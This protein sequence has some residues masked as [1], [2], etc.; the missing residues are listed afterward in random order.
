MCSRHAIEFTVGWHSLAT[1]LAVERA[2]REL[3]GVE[4][5]RRLRSGWHGDCCWGPVTNTKQLVR[6]ALAGFLLG[7]LV[8]SAVA[9]VTWTTRPAAAEAR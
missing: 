7:V 6:D 2:R 9:L 1:G 3:A 5:V 4:G 8:V